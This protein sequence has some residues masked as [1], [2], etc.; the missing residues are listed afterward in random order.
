[1]SGKLVAFTKYG[2]R[3]SAILAEAAGAESCCLAA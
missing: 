1:M 3:S 2:R